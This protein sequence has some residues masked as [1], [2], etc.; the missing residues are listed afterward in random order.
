MRK[1]LNK[2]IVLVM[3]V[4]LSVTSISVFGGTASAKI[5]RK[6]AKILVGKS[7]KL[8]MKNNTKKVKWS[9]SNKKIATVSKKGLVK[10]KKAGKA[11]I[12]AKVGKK[13]YKCKITVKVGLSEIKK[14][15]TEGTS[16][17]L[18]LCGGSKKVKWSSTDNSV[19]TVSK[20]GVVKALKE[21]K[22]S[23]VAKN[24]KKKYYCK[25]IVIKN[26]VEETTKP[27]E[28]AKS[29]ETTK[30]EETAKPQE[31]TKPQ[32]TAKPQETTKP[33]ETATVEIPS[34]LKPEESGS[35]ETVEWGQVF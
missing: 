15:V 6:S 18:K 14:T 33:Q 12:L 29:Q 25:L 23:I 32:E 19:A 21:G 35:G 2:L 9:T 34:T 5:N 13:T 7:I 30:P 27:E 31:T 3:C 20:K 8:K 4:V 26:G 24:G 22:T 11:V 28:T 17:T 10:G 1:L 16:F